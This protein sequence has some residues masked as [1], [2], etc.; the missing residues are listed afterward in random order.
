LDQQGGHGGDSRNRIDTK[1]GLY[2]QLCSLPGLRTCHILAGAGHW[3]QRGRATEV[4][5]LLLME[6]LNDQKNA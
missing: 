6:F 3:I 2:E 1:R 4:N 5:T